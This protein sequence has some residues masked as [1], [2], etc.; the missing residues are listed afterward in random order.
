[1]TQG[2]A[3]TRGTFR[4]ATWNLE[5]PRTNSAEKI[6]ACQAQMRRVNADVWVVTEGH[7]EIGLDDFHHFAT[8]CEGHDHTVGETYTAILS[9]WPSRRH[10][11]EE[12]DPF[13]IWTEIAS[14][15]GDLIVYGTILPY[16]NWRGIGGGSASWV[17][18]LKS[19]ERHRKAWLELRA[20]FPRHRLIVAGNF[21]QN[22]DG[23]RWYGNRQIR[24]ALTAALAEARLFCATQ[25][26]FR[27]PPFG[28]SRARVD[29]ICVD[30]GLVPSLGEVVVW[31]GTTDGTASGAALS[32][33]NGIAVDL[34]G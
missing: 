28:L 34:L 6:A 16:K 17:E 19:I 1:M 31:E 2:L 20:S 11:C 4:L 7:R 8:A 26:D 29:H 25:A 30:Q 13:T 14:P 12:G 10:R 3:Q 15:W 18:H 24:S 9:R 27:A 33:H 32:D 22:R 5:R 21:N 23:T